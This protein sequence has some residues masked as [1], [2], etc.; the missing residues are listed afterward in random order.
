MPDTGG[1]PCDARAAVHLGGMS[2][3]QSQMYAGMKDAERAEQKKRAAGEGVADP[4]A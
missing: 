2:D 3:P 4:T 1:I